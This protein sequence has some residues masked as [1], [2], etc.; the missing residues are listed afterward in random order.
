ML[1][2][3]QRPS[4]TLQ[5]DISGHRGRDAHR[6]GRVAAEGKP[7]AR[8]AGLRIDH[9]LLSPSLAGRLIAAGPD[10]EAPG[11]SI[12]GGA[13]LDDRALATSTSSLLAA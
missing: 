4:V 7:F 1:I 12:A 2:H 8:D 11:A 10:I 5:A 3:N 6:A 13:P 9:L